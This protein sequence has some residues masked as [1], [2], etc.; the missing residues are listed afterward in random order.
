MLLKLVLH[1]GTLNV[2]NIDNLT[3]LI[4]YIGYN[5]VIDYS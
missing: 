2:M 4:Y 3:L 5:K 1:T